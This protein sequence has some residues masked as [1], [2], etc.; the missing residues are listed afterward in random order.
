MSSLA[1]IIPFY[2]RKAGLLAGAL[3]S[4]LAQPDLSDLTV[5]V[6]DDAS[7]VDPAGE[8]KR[9]QAALG[10]GRFFLHRKKNGGP[11]SAR[12]YALD[13]IG[14][15]EMVL[16][17]DSDDQWGPDHLA[18]VR[19]A[20][21]L[22]A[23]LYFADH[24]RAGD[25]QTRFAQT[26][27]PWQDCAEHDGLR[28]W[29]GDLFSLLLCASPVGTSTLAYRYAAMPELRFH[30]VWHGSE[31]TMLWMDITLRARKTL[32]SPTC[33]VSYGKGVNIVAGNHWG[34]VP[35][36]RRLRHACDFHS[37][38]PRRFALTEAQDRW[39]RDW[40]DKLDHSFM[41]SFAAG[42]ARLRL[43]CVAEY[44]RYVAARPQARRALLKVLR[45]RIAGRRA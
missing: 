6:V 8:V 39:N 42:L 33:D 20:A 23:D 7:P 34:S 30:E 12:N 35:D 22:G 26:A 31:D 38:V 10:E 16:F 11:G 3:D 24:I 19:K 41:L 14:N 25:T 13:R 5:H 27:F 2:Q 9:A 40:I 4:V 32:V 15:P 36:L 1:V 21:A 29:T 18:R 43:D 45:D 44:R 37:V 28:E 17:L